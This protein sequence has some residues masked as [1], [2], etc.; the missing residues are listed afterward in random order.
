V[1]IEPGSFHT[2]LGG[3]RMHRSQVIDAHR[4]PTGAT[5]DAVDGMD[6]TQ[7]GDPTKAA[8]AILDIVNTDQKPLRLALGR[9]A[10]EHIRA[11][12]SGLRHDLD[13][14]ETLSLDTDLE[15]ATQPS[16]VPATPRT[17]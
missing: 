6:G 14:W 7:P 4:V 11:T 12:H 17:T 9:D 15:P 3:H 1:I 13:T 5:R 8:R 16:R 10:V 2:E